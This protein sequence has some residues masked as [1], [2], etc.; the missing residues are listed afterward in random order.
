MNSYEQMGLWGE[1]DL[2]FAERTALQLIKEFEPV[3]LQ[4]CPEH[5]YIVGYSG[6]KDS[7]CLV[8]LFIRSGVKFTVIHNHTT[9][10][11][12]DTVRYV[13]K[14][15]ADWTA[16]GIPCEVHKPKE[17]FWQVCIGHRMLP[18]RKARF[19]CAELKENNESYPGATWSFGV[20]RAESKGREQR[21]NNIETRNKSDFSDVQLFHFD[22][23]EEVRNT[24]MCYTNKYFIVNPMAQWST[25]V[26]DAYIAKHHVE[27]NPIYEKYGLDRCG[28]IMCPMASDKQRQR[29][30]RLFPGYAKTFRWLC[31]RI[32]E[33]RNKLGKNADG[34][35]GGGLYER[36]LTPKRDK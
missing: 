36:Y 30:A 29:E 35:T 25:A 20:R 28:C 10:D 4:R 13:R 8:D 2:E 33:E 26:R 22:K 9:L 27:I 31:D 34:I 23:T 18:M 24:D 21:R 19:C 12:P 3:A 17:S 11:I 5:G 7:D 6:G 32:V 14:R 15:F 16:Q 1:S